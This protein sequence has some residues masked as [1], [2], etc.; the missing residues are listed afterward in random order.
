MMKV[1]K[2]QKPRRTRRRPS[3]AEIAERLSGTR[4]RCFTRDG[5]AW[6]DTQSGASGT[7][8]ELERAWLAEVAQ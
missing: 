4:G 3:D 6:R 2:L 1:Q 5:T 7:L 8:E